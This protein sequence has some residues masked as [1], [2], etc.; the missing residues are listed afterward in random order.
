MTLGDQNKLSDLLPADEIGRAW[1]RGLAWQYHRL[2]QLVDQLEKE[3]DH[4]RE[5]RFALRQERLAFAEMAQRILSATSQ[6]L[7]EQELRETLEELDRKDKRRKKF[8]GGGFDVKKTL[9]S[10]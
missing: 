10:A 4:V 8:G 6:R 9:E 7:L 3:K 5:E 1:R 2:Q